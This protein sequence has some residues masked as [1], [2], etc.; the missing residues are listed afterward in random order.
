MKK[1]IAILFAA[2]SLL[3]AQ[4]Q[5][6]PVEGTGWEVCEMPMFANTWLCATYNPASPKTYMMEILPDDPQ[7]TILR[8]TVSATLKATGQEV[9]VTGLVR[10]QVTPPGSVQRIW[11]L[12]TGL[13]FGGEITFP[14]TVVVEEFVPF[15]AP[16]R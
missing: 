2:A 5:V 9:T 14:P 7:V 6:S 4:P 11:T 3:D 15:G 13:Y 16:A 10:V 8:Y 1:V 12:V